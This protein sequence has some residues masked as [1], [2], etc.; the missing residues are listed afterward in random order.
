VALIRDGANHTSYGTACV[1]KYEERWRAGG[2]F[3]LV[4]EHVAIS[5]DSGHRMQPGG[6]GRPCG[7]V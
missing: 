3:G 4:L 5:V 6:A 7:L 2:A 1:A